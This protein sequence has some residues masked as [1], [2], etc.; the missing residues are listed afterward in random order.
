MSTVNY[1][2]PMTAYGRLARLIRHPVT[3]VIGSAAFA[4]VAGYLIDIGGVTALVTGVV[5]LALVLA[6]LALVPVAIV[7]VAVSLV[8]GRRDRLNSAT[9]AARSEL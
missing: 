6:A 9:T 3:I 7:R 4:A 1:P 5:V 2:E 8:R